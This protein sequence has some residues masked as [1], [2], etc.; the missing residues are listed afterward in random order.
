MAKL[1]KLSQELINQ[2][3]AGEVIERPSSVI[4]ELIDNSIDAN[5]TKITVKVK[6]G[7]IEL[8]EVSDNGNGIEKENL[9]DIFLP[10]TTSKISSLEDLEKI[11]TLGFRGEALSTIL[12]ISKVSV[13]SK[14]KVEENAYSVNFDNSKDIIKSARDNGTTISVKNIFFNT[15]ARLKYIKS[16]QTEYR[17]ILEIF[18]EYALSFPNIHFILEK[19]GKEAFNLPQSNILERIKSVI[20]NDFTN[21][22]IQIKF[23]GMGMKVTGFIAHP[24]DAVSKTDYQYIFINSR[25]IWDNGIAKAVRQGYSRF[26]P[27][28]LRTPF[29]LFIDIDSNLLD[30]NVHPRKEEVRFQNPFRVFSSVEQAVSSAL[31]TSLSNSYS[32]PKS[33]IPSSFFDSGNIKYKPNNEIKE[34]KFDKKPSDFNIRK[35]INFSKELL[36]NKLIDSDDSFKSNSFQEPKNVFQIFNKYIVLEFEDTLWMIDQHAAA[37]RINFEK[38]NNQYS[39]K[40]SEIQTLLVPVEL[41]ISELEKEFISE[42]IDNFKK[43]GFDIDLKETLLIK[44]VP[45]FILYEDIE[46]VFRSIFEISDSEDD[47]H[48]K[49]EKKKTDILATMACHGSVRAGQRL[50]IEECLNIYKELG[51]CENPHSCPHGRPAVWRLKLSEIDTN[52]Y[53][54]Y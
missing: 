48:F 53:R 42:N 15:P 5:S 11:H 28:N 1:N 24:N 31:S 25:P 44:S 43:L 19:D 14:E 36:S 49:F 17:K 21:R 10:H 18:I 9:L 51:K 3:A 27:D 29:I 6:K 39:G 50:S 32:Q 47:L 13:N 41:N 2:I 54:T 52:F 12:S 45:S 7:G 23:E 38:L 30:V 33:D 4:K 40:I 35:S 46:N 22:L 34:I 26:I 20:K 8:I 37:E 16:E